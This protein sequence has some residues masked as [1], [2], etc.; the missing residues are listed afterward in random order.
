MKVVAGILVLTLAGAPA[1]FAAPEKL[2]VERIFATGSFGRNASQVTWS[3][4]G[5]RLSFQWKDEEG[6]ALWLLEPPAGKPRRLLPLGSAGL[7]QHWWSPRGDA[8]LVQI[9]G[10]L[11]LLALDGT[12]PRKLLDKGAEDPKFSPDGSRL[13]FVRDYDLYWVEVASGAEH[14]LTRDGKENEILNGTTDWV[15][16]EEIWGRNGTGYWWSPDGQSLAYYRFEE[17]QVPAYPIVDYSPKYPT[18]RWQKY[19]KAGEPNPRVRVGWI[20]AGGGE[21]VWLQTGGAPDDYLARVA[22]APDGETLLVQHLNRDQTVLQLLRCRRGDGSCRPVITEKHGTWVNLG[23]DFH[24]LSDGRFLWGS[25]AGGWRRLNLYAA[26]GKLLRTVSPDGWVVSSL[27]GVTS[28]EQIFFTAYSAGQLGAIDRH[29]FRASLAS[30]SPAENLTPQPGWSTA[31]VAPQSGSWVHTWSDA[32]HPSRLVVRT[33]AGTELARLPAAEPTYDP[34]QLPHWE[35]LTVPGPDGSRLPARLLKPAGFDRTRKYPVV[36][37]HYGGPGSQVVVNQWESRGRGAWHKLMAQRGFGVFMVDNRS[38]LFFGKA[39]EDR[40]HKRFGEVNLEGQLA[41]VDFL[42]SLG[43]ADTSR[44]GLWGWSG[45]GT[46]TLYCI[47]SRPGIWKAAVSGA[48]VTDWSLYDSIWTERYLETPQTNP[49]GFRLSSPLT[50]AKNLQ[51]R[52]LIVHG[53]A[54]DNVHLQNSIVMTREL[55][56][57]QLPFEEAIYPGEK[58][59]LTT[60]GFQ[61]FFARMEEFFVRTL[62]TVEVEDVEVKGN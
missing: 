22:W 32:D 50:L 39:G 28:E 11:R 49:E 5:R 16:W 51:D 7:D 33:A 2:T 13:A 38:S 3:P 26:D 52:L 54:D 15:Y 21:T 34:N 35:F 18:V 61:H 19:P 1:V 27:D 62:D 55:A 47:L 25:E 44:L 29:V 60:P 43:W 57:A 10:E 4:D 59:G 17:S 40:D 45:G 20:A 56:K 36:I 41:G 14:R 53:T 12:P 31:L 9:D 8:L 58:H 46:N 24:L 30:D 37:Y 42:K 48:P 23:D 6:D